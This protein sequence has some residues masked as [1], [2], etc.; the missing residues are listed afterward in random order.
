MQI[1]V[2]L[3]QTSHVHSSQQRRLE[4]NFLIHNEM[5]RQID[6]VKLYLGTE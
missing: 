6:D 4:N 2:G 5:L 3:I 1:G